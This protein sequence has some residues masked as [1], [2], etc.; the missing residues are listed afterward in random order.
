MALA[1]MQEMRLRCAM[2]LVALRR[3]SVGA[4]PRGGMIEE[5][6]H[7]DDAARA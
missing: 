7:D 3:G 6:W 5:A 4:A 2:S 1:M